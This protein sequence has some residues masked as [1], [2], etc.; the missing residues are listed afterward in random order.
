MTMEQAR[1]SA[2]VELH[3]T[4]HSPA[5]IVSLLKYP[6]ST[7]Y[8]VIK[9]FKECG[10]TKRKEHDPQSDKIR[11]PQFLV[12]LKRSV[13]A[14]PE[15]SISWLARDR[16]MSR[17]VISVAINKDLGYKSFKLHVR[18]LLT[19]SHRESRVIRGKQLI[20]SLKSTAGMCNFSWMRNSLLWI[21]PSTGKMTGTY[22]WTQ[23]ASPWSS[24]PR[25]LL[26][27]W[28]WLSSALRA[29]SCHLISSQRALKLIS[30]CTWISWSRWLCLGWR[31]YLGTCPT[32]SSRTL[33]LLTKKRGFSH[34]CWRISTT[35]GQPS[36]I[37]PTALTWT[38][39]I[40]TCGT[41]LRQRPARPAT[42]TSTPWRGPSPPPWAT[43]ILQRLPGPSKL[44]EAMW[45]LW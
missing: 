18:H 39:V 27:S 9:R 31:W 28:S 35:S 45:K 11:S 26:L 42:Q 44:S 13:D 12:G 2:I 24:E 3:C 38:P 23:Q 40:T 7:V 15:R 32:P 14:H 17:H 43:W 16:N 29:M 22:V 1:R 5:T 20:S 33:P 8:D 30:R 41:E 10:D 36:N 4:G 37:P 6:K 19:S 25:N 34:G 21:S